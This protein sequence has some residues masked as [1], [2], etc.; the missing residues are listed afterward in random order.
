MPAIV[1]IVVTVCAYVGQPYAKPFT[2]SEMFLTKQEAV[3]SY[4]AITD[5]EV[6]SANCAYGIYTAAATAP[7]A[8][9]EEQK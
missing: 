8:I 4:N 9:E 5:A 1:Y 6:R 3:E 7:D 2:T